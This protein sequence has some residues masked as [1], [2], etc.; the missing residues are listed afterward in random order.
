MKGREA[1]EEL[2]DVSGRKEN[3]KENERQ[4]KWY[5][6]NS[7]TFVKQIHQS[8]LQWDCSELSKCA[9]L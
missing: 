1:R 7:K 4:N 5:T 3:E 9:Q 8:L 6:L 2:D